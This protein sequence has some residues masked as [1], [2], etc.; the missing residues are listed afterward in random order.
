ME[1][2]VYIT[3]LANE[4]EYIKDHMLYQPMKESFRTM[5]KMT[6]KA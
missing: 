2:I 3:V 5:A 4:I 1:A 6:V